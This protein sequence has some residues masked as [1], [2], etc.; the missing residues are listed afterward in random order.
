MEY[1]T[2]QIILASKIAIIG[3]LILSIL[4]LS[5]GIYSNSYAVIGDSVDSFS[6]VVISFITLFTASIIS[7]PPNPQYP[8]G[9]SKAEAI[10]TKVLSFF[11]IFAGLQLLISMVGQ[12][13]D[14]VPREKPDILAIFVT[15]FSIIG[16]GLLA[17]ALFRIGKRS[18]SKMITA[19]AINMRNDIALSSGVIIGLFFTIQYNMPIVDTYAALIIAIWIIYTGFKIFLDTNEE[20]MDGNKDIDIYTQIF[21]SVN[22]VKGASNPHRTRIRKMAHLYLI[23]LDIEVDP[24]LTVQQAH[25]IAVK[26]EDQIKNDIDNVYDIMLHIE[27]YGNEE[28]EKYG[29]SP[30]DT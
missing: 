5:I 18:E 21:E 28:E 24:N 4:K 1:R 13:I 7:K 9:Y 25:D 23:D 8:F 3:N 30:E 16:K 22:S 17:Y 12:L 11:I 20:L 2:K 15:G 6:D 26:V 10:A 29:L 19:N 14:Q 27:P